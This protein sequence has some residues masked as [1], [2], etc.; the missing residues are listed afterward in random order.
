[1]VVD[2]AP[3]FVG[4]ALDVGLAGLP[5]RIERVELEVEV[6]FG[7]LA[8]VDRTAEEL[9]G[10][11]IHIG[12]PARR[13]LRRREAESCPAGFSGSASA[14]SPLCVR[15]PKKRGPFQAVPVIA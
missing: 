4:L 12:T 1:M 3:S 14:R 15:R 6:M 9:F 10:G 7:R 13:C 5:L 2:Q 11:R 8:R